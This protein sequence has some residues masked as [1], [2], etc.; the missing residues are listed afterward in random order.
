MTRVIAVFNQKGG[1][2]KTTTALSLSSYLALLGKRV[3]L[4]DFDPQF[5]ATVGSGINY[6]DKKTIYHAMFLN[7]PIRETIIPTPIYNFEIIPSSSDLAGAIIELANIENRETHLRKTIEEV[8]ESYDYIIIDMAPSLSLLAINGLMAADEVLIPVQCEYFSLEGV[9]QLLNTI[10]M[11]NENLGHN[12][13]ITGTLLTMYEEGEYL[14]E[15]IVKE[16]REKFPHYVFKTI[17]PKSRSLSEAPSEKRPI[18]IY[19]PRSEGSKK[20]EEL[21]REI[22]NQELSTNSDPLDLNF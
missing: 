17:I 22:I 4:I 3:L 8:K 7:S 2:A 10:Q 20:Y 13:K 11:I 16:M 15:K 21:A 14:P 6:R 9:G 1:T 5:N 19:D 12:L 18:L